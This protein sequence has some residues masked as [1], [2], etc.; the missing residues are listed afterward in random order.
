MGA[1]DEGKL[2]GRS[3]CW[4]R[5]RRWTWR[6]RRRSPRGRGYS[7]VV[8]SVCDF[9]S[10]GLKLSESHCESHDEQALSS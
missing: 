4:R 1:R 9:F 5:R 3:G 8:H 10:E 7:F 6:S 2:D